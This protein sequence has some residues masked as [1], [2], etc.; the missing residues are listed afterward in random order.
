[1]ELAQI[2]AYKT[3]R[4]ASQGDITP[5]HTRIPYHFVFDV[6]FDMR[7]KAR[8]VARG[9]HTQPSKEDIFSGVV[10][11]E[12]VRI[13]FLIAAMNNL[14]VCAADIGN[15][16]LYGTTKEKVF[17]VAG[18]EFG[19]DQGK[20]LI[21]DKGLYGLRSSSARFHEHLSNKLRQMGYSPSRADPD[22]WM[23]KV[24]DR[25]E[26]IA[27]YVDDVL[28]F[29]R[30]PMTVIEELKRDY[31]L[32]GVGKPVYYLGSDVQELGKERGDQ[33]PTMAI[34]AETYICNVVKKFEGIF[35]PLREF[36]S[37]ME[38]NYHPELDTTPLLDERNSSLYRALIGSAN[39]L[40]TL[41][42]LDVHYSTNALSRYAMAPREGHLEAMKRVFGYLK[43]FHKGRIIID[44]AWMDWSKYKTTQEHSWEEIYPNAEEEIPCN[45]PEPRG[46]PARITCFVDADHAHDKVT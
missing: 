5:A 16:F 19:T 30:D 46:M 17:I 21:I 35:G 11:M 23:K 37:P 26:Y 45:M 7:R 1:M 22:F 39:W 42:R 20:W 28:V 18:K 14:K 29:G 15:A 27:A 6:K 40:I 33:G 25:Y 41:G 3:F 13:G 10:G 44:P 4:I 43:K 36:K 8:L 31:V 34:S 32:K 38:L 12:T 2:N 9:N 24:G